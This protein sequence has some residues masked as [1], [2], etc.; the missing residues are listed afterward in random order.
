VLFVQGLATST[1]N[2][3][4][5]VFDT[6]MIT[7]SP[8]R[9]IFSINK[10]AFENLTTTNRIWTTRS[11]PTHGVFS[12]SMMSL[13]APFK[14]NP[15][16]PKTGSL[17]NI[18]KDIQSRQPSWDIWSNSPSATAL[19]SR[20]ATVQTASVSSQKAPYQAV[21]SRRQAATP[22]PPDMATLLPEFTAS[23]SKA[24]GETRM[25]LLED[26]S[27]CKRS[28]MSAPED[29][30]KRRRVTMSRI[31]RDIPLLPRE[32]YVLI[33]EEIHDKRSL[34]RLCLVSQQIQDLVLPIL[35]RD[36]VITPL[37]TYHLAKEPK[38]GKGTTTQLQMSL[39]TRHIAMNGKVCWKA[40]GNMVKTLDHLRSIT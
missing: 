8:T 39:Y 34:A 36:I 29:E 19:S 26:R 21:S 2:S 22:V 18:L 38:V 13:P 28:H 9:D 20:S 7:I 14:E 24:D 4:T 25:A 3:L 12:N 5:Y 37:I 31:S 30:N 40:T 17:G 15:E 33:F 11:S 1:S 27:G 6:M 10:A 32:V 16:A 35:Y 23:V